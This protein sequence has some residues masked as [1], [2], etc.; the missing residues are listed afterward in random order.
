LLL[1]ALG[2]VDDIPGGAPIPR[3]V[4]DRIVGSITLK[5]Y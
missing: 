3:E 1:A 2:P 5:K 4:F